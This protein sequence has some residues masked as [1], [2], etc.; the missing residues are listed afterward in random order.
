[1]EVEVEVG[2]PG[3]GWEAPCGMGS[4][5]GKTYPVQTADPLLGLFLLLPSSTAS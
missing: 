1:M 5:I 4:S 3:E 2:H